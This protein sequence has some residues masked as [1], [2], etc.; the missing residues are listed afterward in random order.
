MFMAA[1][2]RI[3]DWPF[4]VYIYVRSVLNF[5]VTEYHSWHVIPHFHGVPRSAT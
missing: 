1:K 5:R 2:V 4:N 3:R